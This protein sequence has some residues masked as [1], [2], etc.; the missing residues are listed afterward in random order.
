ME[1]IFNAKI[2]DKRYNHFFTRF[3]IPLMNGEL[4]EEDVPHVFKNIWDRREHFRKQ[5]QTITNRNGPKIYWLPE[6]YWYDRFLD[7][8]VRNELKPCTIKYY[9]DVDCCIEGCNVMSAGG[10]IPFCHYHDPILAKTAKDLTERL[11]GGIASIKAERMAPAYLLRCTWLSAETLYIQFN[12]EYATKI[13]F[14]LRF[15]FRFDED[16]WSGVQ[17][18]VEAVVAFAIKHEIAYPIQFYP[19]YMSIFDAIMVRA[20]KWKRCPAYLLSI[21][22]ALSQWAEQCSAEVKEYE[23]PGAWKAEQPDRDRTAELRSELEGM[24]E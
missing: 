13:E 6:K 23:V 15:I 5:W 17:E 19:E 11:E 21:F 24:K 14:N 4:R 18:R 3:F 16:Q 20:R 1:T 8:F 7:S 10:E 2:G 12:R 22:N 9:L